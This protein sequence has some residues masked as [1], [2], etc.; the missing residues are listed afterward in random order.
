LLEF[1]QLQDSESIRIYNYVLFG[2]VRNLFVR[3]EIYHKITIL[4]PSRFNPQEADCCVFNNLKRRMNR[5]FSLVKVD[6]CIG[7][8]KCFNKRW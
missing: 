5:L 1:S 8:Q 2:I 3:L 4:D 6:C 7:L